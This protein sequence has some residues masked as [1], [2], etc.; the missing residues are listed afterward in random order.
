[1][2]LPAGMCLYAYYDEQNH[3]DRRTVADPQIQKSFGINA[4]NQRGSGIV[5]ASLGQD[6]H[7]IKN[8]KGADR[9]DY[10][11]C[12][13]YTSVVML[14]GILNKK[15]NRNLAMAVTGR[16]WAEKLIKSP[17]ITFM[18]FKFRIQSDIQYGGIRFNQ[19]FR[20]C[21]HLYRPDIFFR[22]FIHK[23]L[24]NTAGMSP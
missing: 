13:L 22:C 3:P 12:L 4:V 14:T 24:K 21:G 19:R 6:T 5:G 8:L 17:R 9:T 10:Q 11:G 15:R 2:S 23:L 7:R 20:A 1:M 16:S 18:A